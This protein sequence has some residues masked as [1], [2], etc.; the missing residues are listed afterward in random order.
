MTIQ[1]G[2]ARKQATR[3]SNRPQNLKPRTGSSVASSVCV[4]FWR[5]LVEAM[6]R[7]RMLVIFGSLLACGRSPPLE[8]RGRPRCRRDFDR[9]ASCNAAT[10][11]ARHIVGLTAALLSHFLFAFEA[12]LIVLLACVVQRQYMIARRCITLGISNLIRALTRTRAQ[13]ALPHR[14]V[15]EI[16]DV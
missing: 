2:Q 7:C 1:G 12:D 9:E 14:K 15:G 10:V 13:A 3:T 6:R 11:G 16:V 5:I 4:A 8:R